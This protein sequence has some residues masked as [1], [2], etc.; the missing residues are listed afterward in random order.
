MHRVQV[1]P[2]V[3]QL[4]A[5]LLA[6]GRVRRIA[7]ADYLCRSLARVLAASGALRPPLLIPAARRDCQQARQMRGLVKEAGMVP[8]AAQ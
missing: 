4:P 8:K 7:V 5:P 2:G 1:P 6:G 3:A